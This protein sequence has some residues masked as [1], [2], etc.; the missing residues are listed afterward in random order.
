MTTTFAAVLSVAALTVSGCS[1]QQP[2]DNTQS[3]TFSLWD[4]YPQFDASSDW[5]KV[6]DKCGAQAGVSKVERQ[7]F[8][9][10]DLTNKVLLAAQQDTAPNVLVVDN[11]VVSTL[12]EAGVLKSNQ[13]TGLDA[14]KAA[15]NLVAAGQ[16]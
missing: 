11:P 14:T 12:A 6:I 5:A 4:P 9:T 8:D 2:A 7:A 10:T 1:G 15:P 3:T 16:S 13:D